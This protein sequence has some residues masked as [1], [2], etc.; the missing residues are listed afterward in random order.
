MRKIT[1]FCIRFLRYASI[2]FLYYCVNLLCVFLLL[3]TQLQ[4]VSSYKNVYNHTGC[5]Q[6]LCD[7]EETEGREEMLRPRP[8]RSNRLWKNQQ[9]QLVQSQ[10]SHHEKI[11]CSIGTL[12]KIP[13]CASKGGFP[14]STVIVIPKTARVPTP[15]ARRRK[16]T[17]FTARRLVR[18]PPAP[19][20]VSRPPGWWARPPP[21][22]PAT[23]CAPPAPRRAWPG[24]G[25]PGR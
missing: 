21:R 4:I 12:L 9:F 13:L 6:D 17:A 8:Y 15:S 23:G 25:P 7:A 19:A 14:V 22:R 2:P 24:A 10:G 11:T 5:V 1:H 16:S 20:P 3:N 18:L